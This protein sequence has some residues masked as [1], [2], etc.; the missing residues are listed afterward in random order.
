MILLYQKALDLWLSNF[1]EDKIIGR[2]K[3]MRIEE[4]WNSEEK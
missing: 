3:E 1:E 2:I 4:K